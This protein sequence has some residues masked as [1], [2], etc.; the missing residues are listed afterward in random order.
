LIA[1]LASVVVVDS[2]SQVG[3]LDAEI[4]R[5]GICSSRRAGSKGTPADGIHFIFLRELVFAVR[6]S[7]ESSRGDK[8]STYTLYV[9]GS[10]ARAALEVLVAGDPMDICVR[11]IYAPTPWKVDKATVRETPPG[12][13]MRAI[14]A[15]I[16][17]NI[18]ADY[19][20]TRRASV[21]VA[22][23]SGI[24]KTCIGDFLATEMR[25]QMG[26][27]PVVVKQLDLTTAGVSVSEVIGQPTA[28]QP[29]VLVFDEFDA[30][31][32]HAEGEGDKKGDC[33]SIAANRGSL[34]G[35]LDRLGASRH[36]IVIAT[37]NRKIIDL[38]TAYVR[39]GRFNRQFD[40]FRVE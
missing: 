11:Y 27:D 24:G 21:I 6:A 39:P 22:G 26:V 10:A 1:C 30:T 17:R 13:K 36:V 8:H 40:L 2:A 33:R 3:T 20:K 34:L 12:A 9:F 7:A 29:I 35:F 4:G 31:I 5:A 15:T 16:V 25:K 23:Q 37:T 19:K 38:D 32:V 28:S 14:Q 18:I